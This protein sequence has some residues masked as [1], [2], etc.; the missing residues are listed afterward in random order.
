VIWNKNRVNEDVNK[1]SDEN[2][3]KLTKIMKN[4]N[5]I[6]KL[7]LIIPEILFLMGWIQNWIFYIKIFRINILF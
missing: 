3:A 5:K 7:Y 1:N 6:K 2:K 4:K